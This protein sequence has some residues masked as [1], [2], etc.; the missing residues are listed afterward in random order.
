MKPPRAAFIDYRLGHT[1]GKPHDR[2]DQLALVRGAL[3][4]LH[5]QTESGA[6]VDLGHTW[7]QD[8]SWKE[9]P[10]SSGSK[11]GDSRGSRSPEPVYQT[12]EDRL[13]ATARHAPPPSCRSCVGIDVP[14]PHH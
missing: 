14:V 13:L 6:I 8:E 3:R 9:N 7:S 4:L 2:S 1:S 10:L 11:S 12:E 5:E